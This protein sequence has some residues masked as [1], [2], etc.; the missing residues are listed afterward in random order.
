MTF[1]LCKGVDMQQ[2]YCSVQIKSTY[3]ATVKTILCG[4]AF[5]INYRKSPQ[6]CYCQHIT[7]DSCLLKMLEGFCVVLVRSFVT[8]PAAR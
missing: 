1:K 3:Y 5:R 4:L 6:C 8:E 7:K 2:L